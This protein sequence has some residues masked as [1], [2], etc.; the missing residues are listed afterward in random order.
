MG[1]WYVLHVITGKEEEVKQYLARRV[2][3][4]KIMIPRRIMMELHQ[5]QWIKE[6]KELFP[7][8]IFVYTFMDAAMYYKL[9]GTPS[10]IKILG[11]DYGP[12]PVPEDEINHIL[13]F[14][15]SGDPL[16]ISEMYKIG[17][18]IKV[19]SGALTG[20]EGKIVKVDARRQRAKVNISLMGQPRIVELAIKMIIKSEL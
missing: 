15:G 14:H 11:S 9:T 5:R 17:N 6:T 19:A 8:Y 1:D 20:L 13:R 12:Q 18:Q 4:C 3:E 2:P 7:G 10:V 16:G